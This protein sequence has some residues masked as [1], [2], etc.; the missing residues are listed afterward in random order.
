M[1]KLFYLLVLVL[2]FNFNS[3]AQTELTLE[4]PTAKI[5][6][7]VY[8]L[9]GFTMTDIPIVKMT[10][11][12]DNGQVHQTGNMIN[13][14]PDG[15]WKMYNRDGTILSEMIYSYG[16]KRVLTNYTANGE[17][18]VH[19]IDNKPYKHTQVAYLD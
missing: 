16:V 15:V 17:S 4:N 6:N 18:V 13:K 8:Q 14:K 5:E 11:Y 2:A 10:E 1:K 12:Y 19:Y 3:F 7:T 9:V